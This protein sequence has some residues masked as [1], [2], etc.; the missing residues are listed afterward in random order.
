MQRTINTGF[1]RSLLLTIFDAKCWHCPH[2]C[3]KVNLFENE[4][5]FGQTSFFF[6]FFQAYQ[7]ANDVY[8]CCYVITSKNLCFYLFCHPHVNYDSQF[9]TIPTVLFVCVC[10]EGLTGQ[11]VSFFK[12]KQR[13]TI[14]TGCVSTL[15][16]LSEGLGHAHH[17][18]STKFLK[19]LVSE[20]S[21]V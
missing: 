17:A 4:N 8:R 14:E 13:K 1:Y 16:Y 3:V 9:S 15:V 5:F 6:F 11:K 20:R 21:E 12:T 7:F 10:T 19:G 2:A 18:D